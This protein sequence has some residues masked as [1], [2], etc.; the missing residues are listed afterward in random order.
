M[1][2][3]GLYQ[4]IMTLKIGSDEVV[5]H[6][7]KELFTQESAVIASHFDALTENKDI[8]DSLKELQ[9]LLQ[10][11]E[12]VKIGKG[13]NNSLE[14][15]MDDL[16]TFFGK[17]KNDLIFSLADLRQFLL[18]QLA[19][20]EEGFSPQLELRQILPRTKGYST[21]I[22]SSLRNRA[23][24]EQI[25][26]LEATLNETTERAVQ[27]QNAHA[28]TEGTSD[29]KNAS[30]VCYRLPREK[31]STVD[32]VIHSVYLRRVDCTEFE[33]LINIITLT[34]I[35]KMDKLTANGMKIL[36]KTNLYQ[37]YVRHA[38]KLPKEMLDKLLATDA[39][40]IK[41]SSFVG[42]INS[43]SSTETLQSKSCSKMHL[44]LAHWS[45][46][47]VRKVFTLPRNV[48][49]Q[50]DLEAKEMNEGNLP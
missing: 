3:H 14:E 18:V 40:D 49:K 43:I 45:W 44:L 26:I 16:L 19:L 39:R 33:G 31:I 29:F 2:D 28:V 21:R 48:L 36:V 25:K 47:Y 7:H 32:A 6:V 11:V 41:A 10:N 27:R 9:K 8:D 1:P 13:G 4:T 12:T 20:D 50:L 37:H 46:H 38:F 24:T 15:L 42:I 23:Y 5:R 34:A 17:M 22:M 30:E 35:L